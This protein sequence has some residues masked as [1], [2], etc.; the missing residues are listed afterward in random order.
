MVKKT[1]PPSEPDFNQGHSS[2]EEPLWI[3]ED[4][5]DDQPE[6]TRER[7][8]LLRG[9]LWRLFSPM[10]LHGSIDHLISN[11]FA[12]YTL[13]IACEHM[14]SFMQAGIVYFFS[15]LC[16][17]LLSVLFQ[18]GP[19]VG[20]SGAIFGLM[21][22]VVV[23][24]YKYQKSFFIRDRRIG[25][26]IGAWGYIQLYLDSSLPMLTTLPTLGALLEVVL[27]CYFSSHIC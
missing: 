7:G 9:E 22:L 25:T 21:A 13:G 20:A 17:S 3:S 10:F 4:M 26:V 12:L 2:K 15:G 27:G 14:L 16:G 24:L 23:F 11:C 18:P 19:S 5:L 8:H 1:N 6:D